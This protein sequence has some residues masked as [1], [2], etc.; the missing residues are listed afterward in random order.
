MQALQFLLHCI[1]S[2]NTRTVNTSPFFLRFFDGSQSE[3][4]IKTRLQHLFS[5]HQKV[6]VVHSMAMAEEKNSEVYAW[7]KSLSPGLKLERLY[8]QFDSRGFR[9]RRSL[10]Y[11]KSEDLDSFFPSPDKLLL[12]ERRILEAEI[13][14]IRT[15]SSRNPGGLEPRKL[16]M[17][18]G[19]GVKPSVHGFSSL[20]QLTEMPTRSCE[21]S[22]LDRRANE[23]SENLQLLEAQVESIRCNIEE[24]R[25]ALDDLPS[26]KRGK[27]CA[28]CHMSGHNRA[29]CK[30]SPCLNVS[31]CQVKD[32]HPEMQNDIRALQRD[33][34]ELERKYAK[35]KSDSDVFAASR[36]RAKSS[37]FAVMR[38]R[39][40][41]QNPAK[42]VDRSALD[43]DL[44]V[45]QRALNNKVPLDE[46]LD[47]TLPNIIEQYKRGMPIGVQY[48]QEQRD[49]HRPPNSTHKS[50]TH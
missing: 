10:A 26:G 49:S 32:K 15:D 13:N 48:H 19:V 23:L 17:T 21:P 24:K 50:T 28:I 4:C 29:K 41:T 45:L 9:S 22:P 43:R 14:Q 38:P 37:F 35:M 3:T 8:P 5:Q 31:F 44:M 34:K 39:L 33:L 27:V 30:G 47:W 1:Y 40:R 16:V 42:Y 2:A 20:Q 46:G 12:A 25:K 6:R 18:P 36:E 7:L 11:V